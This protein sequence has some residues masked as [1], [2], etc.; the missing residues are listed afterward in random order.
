MKWSAIKE[1]L[2]VIV[3]TAIASVV[4]LLLGIVYFGITLW[5]I[6]N[7]SLWFFG[8]GLE[9]NWAVMAAAVLSA[10]SVIAGAMEKKIF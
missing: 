7:A 6:K 8:V 1:G 4:L 9:A 10:S 2:G 5:V 3:V